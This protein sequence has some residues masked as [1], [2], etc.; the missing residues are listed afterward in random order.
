MNSILMTLARVEHPGRAVRNIL[1]MLSLLF[2]FTSSSA[3]ECRMMA[4]NIDTCNFAKAFAKKISQE[5]PKNISDKAKLLKVSANKSQLTFSMY[6]T[7]TESEINQ[8]ADLAEYKDRWL[9]SVKRGLCMKNTTTNEFIQKGGAFALDVASIDGGIFVRKDITDC[10]VSNKAMPRDISRPV[11][12]PANVP[13]VSS[14]LPDNY[15]FIYETYATAV[16]QKYGKLM[17]FP[18]DAQ[19]RTVETPV[20]ITLKI[21]MDGTLLGTSLDMHTDPTSRQAVRQAYDASPYPE[22]PML[23]FRNNDY[24]EIEITR[25]AIRHEYTIN[26]REFYERN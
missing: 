5:L 16:M 15:K 12:Q 10:T 9:E 1:L 14:P 11:K 23:L 26:D 8:I 22:P 25:R 24:L 4:N 19:G 13:Q 2:A 17:N 20:S 7:Y 21:G 6:V 3:A 18:H